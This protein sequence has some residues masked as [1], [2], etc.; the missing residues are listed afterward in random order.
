MLRFRHQ[1]K[2]YVI[3]TQRLLY[4]ETPLSNPLKTS[5]KHQ[6]IAVC[7]KEQKTIPNTVARTP[8]K[9]KLLGY[10]N[11]VELFGN[12]LKIVAQ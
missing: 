1:D 5:V 3:K 2:T 11:I 10:L 8:G 7:S 6:A 12:G 4:A 9:A